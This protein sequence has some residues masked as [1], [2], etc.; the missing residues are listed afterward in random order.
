MK[1]HHA[2]TSCITRAVRIKVIN[3][4]LLTLLTEWDQK[5]TNKIIERLL[6]SNNKLPHCYF[7]SFCLNLMSA[8]VNPM[9]CIFS[10]C[11]IQPHI[12]MPHQDRGNQTWDRITHISEFGSQMGRKHFQYTHLMTFKGQK[13]PIYSQNTWWANLLLYRSVGDVW[14]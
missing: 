12:W 8:P 11:G 13:K 7:I 2:D 14:E 3:R 10:W 9:G 5:Y 4:L 1:M 6:L